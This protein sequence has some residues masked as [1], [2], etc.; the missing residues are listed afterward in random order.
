MTRLRMA[1]LTQ[2]QWGEIRA[3]YEVDGSSLGELEREYNVTKQAISKK[4]KK[5]GWGKGQSSHLVAGKVQAVRDLQKVVDESSQLSSHHQELIADRSKFI[6]EM[7]GIF[8]N[9]IKYN[10]VK[11]NKILKERAEN[12]EATL[13]DFNQHSQITARNKEQVMGKSPDT[14]IQINN[15]N[16][17]TKPFSEL[18]GTTEP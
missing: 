9:A 13:S 1:R 12:Q 16:E 2:E 5:E 4:V 6:L 3:R 17:N 15:T 7:E 11:A 18:Y 14:A 10:Q 8:D